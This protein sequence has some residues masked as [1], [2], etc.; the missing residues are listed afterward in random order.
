M[1]RVDILINN[2]GAYHRARVCDMPVE[3]FDE[4]WMV[5]VRAPFLLIRAV[6]P[7][8]VRR[9][10]G[11]IVG[12]A[13]HAG[14]SAGAFGGAYSTSKHALVALS[15][16]VQKEHRADGI[17]VGVVL[18]G[19]VATGIFDRPLTKEEE[20]TWLQP[21]DIANAVIFLCSQRERARVDQVVIHPMSQDP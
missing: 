11:I 18:P 19:Y 5:N 3:D 17:K 4:T 14:Y 16:V 9:H 10:H 2:A 8:M 20:R 6:L 13:S 1:G 21:Q 7:G 15:E 12:I